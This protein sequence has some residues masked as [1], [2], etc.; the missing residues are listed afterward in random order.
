MSGRKY[1]QVM[2]L[3]RVNIQ[4]YEELTNSIAKK[5]TKLKNPIK[6]QTE[7]LNRYFPKKIYR[8]PRDT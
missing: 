4:K 8:Y 7:D 5:K 1:W 2:Y 6:I 3:I